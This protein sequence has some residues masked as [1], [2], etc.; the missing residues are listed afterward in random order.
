MAP[1]RPH[2]TSTDW[3]KVVKFDWW[4]VIDVDYIIAKDFF[5][6]YQLIYCSKTAIIRWTASQ[7]EVHALLYRFKIKGNVNNNQ[8][9]MKNNFQY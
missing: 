9:Y 4:V 7:P 5:K 2:Y 3:S 8:K 1:L 6:F